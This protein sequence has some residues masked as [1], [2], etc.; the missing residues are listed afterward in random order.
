MAKFSNFDEF[1]SGT[2]EHD[3]LGDGA[4]VAAMDVN[5]VIPGFT[6]MPEHVKQILHFAIKTAS[7][8]ATAGLLKTEPEKAF[9][10]VQERMKAWQ[11]GTWRSAAEGAGEPRSS[12]LIKALAEV[13]GESEDWAQ[14]KFSEILE[15]KIDEAQL[16]RDE[17]NDKK[18]IA[19]IRSDLRKDFEKADD[20][21]KVLARLRAEEAAKRAEAMDAKETTTSAAQLLAR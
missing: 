16:S 9:Q 8:N 21:A 2:F 1:S 14:E 7:R 15:A 20:V 17:D 13:M 12:L 19:K 4:M 10:R 18:A 3:L 11:G 5:S 6:N